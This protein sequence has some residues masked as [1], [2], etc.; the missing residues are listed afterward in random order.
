MVE[1]STHLQVIPQQST[2][3]TANL[4]LQT[5]EKNKF[6]YCSTRIW[7]LVSAIT[8]LTQVPLQ[9]FPFLFIFIIPCCDFTWMGVVLCM[10]DTLELEVFYSPFFLDRTNCRTGWVKWQLLE[11]LWR[12]MQSCLLF[13]WAT[14][15]YH[16]VHCQM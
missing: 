13:N 14:C 8:L 7:T 5:Y 16:K 1:K 9:K 11:F 10:V 15:S 12:S 2:Q 6:F 4:P 3:N